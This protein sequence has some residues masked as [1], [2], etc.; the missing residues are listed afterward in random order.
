MEVHVLLPIASRHGVQQTSLSPSSTVET[1]LEGQT[2]SI[3][4]SCFNSVFFL[5]PELCIP[6][7]EKRLYLEVCAGWAT[8][9]P[10]PFGLLPG[11]LC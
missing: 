10:G 3:L 8:G 7:K 5:P 6:E 4:N 9:A 1:A 2:E 11:S